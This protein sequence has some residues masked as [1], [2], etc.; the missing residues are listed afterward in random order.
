MAAVSDAFR[1]DGERFV[2]DR[3]ET[4]FRPGPSTLVGQAPDGRFL[5]RKQLPGQATRVNVVVN[6][7]S[8][9]GAREKR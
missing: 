8:A 9:L 3:E 4:L 5:V 7:P 1:L 2:V 6:W